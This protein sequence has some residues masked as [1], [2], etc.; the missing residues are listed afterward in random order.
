M[1]GFGDGAA[2]NFFS[3]G[4]ILT[5]FTSPDPPSNVRQDGPIKK[6]G[7]LAASKAASH[8]AHRGAQEAR[9][10]GRQRA[11][12]VAGCSLTHSSPVGHD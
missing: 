2:H 6:I 10:A 8:P 1:V 9:A 4:Q 7:I 5:C 12:F 3:G 11:A